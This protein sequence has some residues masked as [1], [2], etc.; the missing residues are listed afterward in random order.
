MGDVGAIEA[1]GVERAALQAV[2]QGQRGGPIEPARRT[3]EPADVGQPPSPGRAALHELKHVAT[4]P[5]RK[6]PPRYGRRSLSQPDRRGRALAARPTPGQY[7]DLAIDATVRAAAPAQRR[8]L[9]RGQAIAVQPSDLHTKVRRRRAGRLILFAVDASWSVSAA[10]RL[11]AT[12]GAVLSLLRDAYVRRDR[13]GPIV[14]QGREARLVLPFTASVSRAE[15]ALADLPAGGKTPLSHALLLAY[16][17]FEHALRHDAKAQPLLVLLTDAAGNVAVG[18]MPPRDEALRYAGLFAARHIPSVVVDVQE[19]GA[20]RARAQ[21]L[22]RA[23]RGEW[24]AVERL[25]AD[26]LAAKVR[27]VE[28]GRSPVR[29]TASAGEAKG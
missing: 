15:K 23:L 8:R 20:D 13:V 18:D 14:F 12:R 16:R 19:Q 17:T 29:V 24:L 27:E 4:R 6:R 10:A 2:R 5:P 11:A 1:G 3:A 26:A 9:G 21:E 25:R 22:A 28:A 7:D